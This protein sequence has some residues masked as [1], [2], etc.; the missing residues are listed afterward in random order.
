[1][2]NQEEFL[3]QLREAFAIE[4]KEH[5]QTIASALLAFEETQGK[6]DQELIETTYRA[7]HS[8]KGAARAVD[9]KDIEYICHSIE[10][11]FQALKRSELRINSQ[12]LD[13]LHEALH[14]IELILANSAVPAPEISSICERLDQQVK[15]G[16][17]NLNPPPKSPFAAESPGAPSSPPSQAMVESLPPSAPASPPLQPSKPATPPPSPLSVQTASPSSKAET[18]P[19]IPSTIRIQAE[20]LDVLLRKS[21]N[22]IAIKQLHA[23]IQGQLKNALSMLSE[24]SSDLQARK[25]SISIV[26]TIINRLASESIHISSLI[27]SLIEETQSVLMLP[28]SVLFDTFPISAHDIAKSLGKEVSLEISGQSIELEKR[29]LEK[30]KDP[31]MHI[32]RNAIDHGIESPNER[33]AQ[34]KPRRGKITIRVA[35]LDSHNIEIIIADDGKGID[36]ETIRSTAI[37]KNILQESEAQKKQPEE[38]FSLLFES[39]FSTSKII[40]DL[41]GRGLGM[42]IVKEALDDLEGSVHIES[43]LGK[44]TSFHLIIPYTKASFKGNVIR[45]GKQSFVL[46]SSALEKGIRIRQDAITASGTTNTIEY[47]NQPIGIVHLG[48]ILGISRTLETEM[49]DHVLAVICRA[50][51]RVSAFIIDEILGEQDVLIKPL[52]TLLQK[53]RGIYGAT[54][55]PN[56]EVIPILNMKEILE[57]AFSTSSGARGNAL[58]GKASQAET[59]DK[60]TNAKRILVVEDSITSRTLI[61]S[62]LSAAGFQVKAAVD[63]IEGFT[64]LKS[65][66]FDLVVSDVEMPRLD[67]FGL[68][69]RIRKD[70]A[71]ANIPVILVT[72]LESKEHKEKGIAVGANAYITKS[73]FAQSN[74]LDTVHRFI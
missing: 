60:T 24:A 28:C 59:K 47:Q 56:D 4:S 12:L 27:D 15:N 35:H 26:S 22:L 25:E 43:V 20:R 42:A 1:M 6:P 34:G 8:L 40:T 57:M 65:E 17:A 71:L 62:I 41:S 32:L 53:V 73:N 11:V 72:A 48:D 23:Q 64:L 66:P 68:T 50:Q 74:L 54:I 3:K 55:G 61:T 29:I 18:K 5:I 10:S 19:S 70:P 52:G 51:D 13:M 49:S 38:L 36:P 37:A 58:P 16:N 9:L 31:L 14:L 44:G 69:E 63:G 67:G 39:G 45:V 21:E 2:L 46:P 33:E 30:L 7:V